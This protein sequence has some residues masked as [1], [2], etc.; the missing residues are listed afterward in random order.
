MSVAWTIEGEVGKP[1]DETSKTFDDIGIDGSTLEFPALETDV[2]SL[3]ISPEDWKTYTRPELGQTVTLKRDGVTFFYGTVTNDQATI[4][5]SSQIIT[6]EVSGPW[7]WMDR[8]ELT[9]NQTDGSGGT[10]DRVSYVFGTDAGV[11]LKTAIETMI[12]RAIAL[13]VPMQ[14][15][16][17]ATF[18]D[19]PR[20]TLNQ[21][22]CAQAFTELLRLVPDCFAW[23]D[24]T[25][26]P[27][28]LNVDRRGVASVTTITIGTDNLTDLNVKPIY[29]MEVSRVELD[30]VDRSATGLT[31]FQQQ[32]SGTATTGRVQIITISG[33]EIDTFLPNELFETF[34][35]KSV[36]AN[37][38]LA[39]VLKDPAGLP[40]LAELLQ[41]YPEGG[42]NDWRLELGSMTTPGPASTSIQTVV[43][44]TV[45]DTLTPP[46]TFTAQATLD[47]SRKFILPANGIDPPE[48]VISEY[49]VARY[50]VTQLGYS[51][52]GSVTTIPPFD[53]QRSRELKR[54]FSPT[55]F[56]SSGSKSIPST[57]TPPNYGWFATIINEGDFSF[58]TIPTANLPAA[59]NPE[60]TATRIGAFTYELD[61][62]PE[63]IEA[64]DIVRLDLTAGSTNRTVSSVDTVNNRV[65]FTLLVSDTESPIPFAVT[66]ITFYELFRR[67]DYSFIAPPANLAANLL[68]AQ[69]FVPYEGNLRLVDQ[70]AGGTRYAGTVVNVANSITEHSTMKAL[71][72]NERL[73]LRAGTTEIVLGTPE[74]IDYRTFVDRI[75][76]TP[77]DNV[78]FV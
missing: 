24:Y 57:V 19:V 68:A 39:G 45:T 35:I 32:A 22:T 70:D 44:G 71:I 26:S 37:T 30:Y 58:W 77:Q 23:F 10:A 55:W 31:Q 43:A 67:A 53:A 66:S 5:G 64:G 73:D 42:A 54:V 75:R 59:S 17:V 60:G 12:D 4:S 62:F 34:T 6:I 78:I 36:Y 9:E 46:Q 63:D 52:G 33:K 47:A 29:E 51:D 25:T 50:N 76:S 8:I 27:P 28:T 69:D 65:T 11:D 56:W 16:T 20:I 61:P 15:G 48:W 49:G 2:L 40:G 21:S 13:G 41:T 74:R 14:R 18:F 1:W 3:A 7:W 72:S 38:D